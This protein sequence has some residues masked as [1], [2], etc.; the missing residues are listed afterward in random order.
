M[1]DAVEQAMSR[2]PGPI[3]LQSSPWLGWILFAISAGAAIVAFSYAATH[4]GGVWLVLIPIVPLFGFSLLMLPGGNTLT[5]DAAGF[6]M[7]YMRFGR[8]RT[9]WPDVG[10]F[11]TVIFRGSRIVVFNDAGRAGSALAKLNLAALGRNRNLPATY[12]LPATDLA[13]LLARW[14]VRATAGAHAPRAAAPSVADRVT[15]STPVRRIVR[16]GL[17]VLQTIAIVLAVL[18]ALVKVGQIFHWFK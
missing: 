11:T 8:K 14:R 15:V 9:S 17:L 7:R 13:D 2:F 5:L 18:L 6:E 16:G 1:S 3:V 12:G 10:D 4:G